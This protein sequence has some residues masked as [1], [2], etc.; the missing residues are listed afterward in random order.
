MATLQPPEALSQ[1]AGDELWKRKSMASRKNKKSTSQSI[2][3]NQSNPTARTGHEFGLQQHGGLDWSPLLRIAG[4]DKP[5]GE[6][7]QAT[8]PSSAIKAPIADKP[9]AANKPEDTLVQGE[10]SPTVGPATVAPP[11]I[12]VSTQDDYAQIDLKLSIQPTPILTKKL[13]DRA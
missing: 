2:A 3:V 11:T 13:T 12:T 7:L 6:L 10:D 8:A 9:A 5:I 1:W 4:R